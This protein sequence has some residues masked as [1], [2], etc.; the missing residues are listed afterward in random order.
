MAVSKFDVSILSLS[1]AQ[2]NFQAL[3]DIGHNIAESPVNDGDEQQ[4]LAL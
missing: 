4:D 2:C 1:D 3:A